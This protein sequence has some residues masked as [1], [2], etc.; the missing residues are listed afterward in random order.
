MLL[1][2]RTFTLKTAGFWTVFGSLFMTTAYAQDGY[3]VT[4]ENSNVADTGGNSG[5]VR[6]ARIAYIQGGASWRTD[7]TSDW[8]TANTNL[9]LRQGAS[10]SVNS[11][12]RTEVQ[13]DDGS[14][15][16]LGS[17]T[18]V[19]FQTLYSDAHGEFTELKFNTGLASITLVSKASVFQLDT[20]LTSIKAQGPANIRI[21]VSKGVEVAVRKGRIECA[22]SQGSTILNGGD[23]V[24]MSD[25][26][27]PL[28]VSP[29]PASDNWDQFNDNRDTSYNQPAPYIPSN[30]AIMSG[31]L[32][33]YGSWSAH[34]KYGHIWRP[35]GMHSGWRPYQDGHWVWVDPFGW[36]W[37]GTE[38]WGW[39]PYHYGSWLHDSVGWG[40]APG[41]RQ[42]Y[43]SPAV[44]SFSVYN[45]NVA[46]V[47][48]SPAEMV[49]PAGISF[50][51]QGGDWSLSFAIGGAAAYYP[52][53]QG[54]VVGRP[55]T[56]GYLNRSYNVYNQNRISGLY[57]GG[58]SGANNQF[59]PTYGRSS[60][61]ITRTTS[62]GFGGTGRYMAGTSVDANNFQ[63]GHSFGAGRSSPSVFGPA[64]VRPVQTS[65]TASRKFGA[66]RPYA[67]V[68]DRSVIRTRLPAEALKHSAPMSRSFAPATRAASVTRIPRR[69]PIGNGVRS[70]GPVRVPNN[71]VGKTNPVRTNG[72]GNQKRT[73]GSNPVQPGRNQKAAPQKRQAVQRTQK[74]VPQNRQAVQRAQKAAPQKRQAVQRTQKA[75]PQKRQ[76]VQRTQKAAPQKRQ[77]VQRTQKAAPQQRQAVQRQQRPAPQQ[78]Q[79]VQRQQRPA[80]QQRQA[81]QRQQRP[82]TQQRQPM[83]RQQRAAPQKRP[84]TRSNGPTTNNKKRGGG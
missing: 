58:F 76:A 66:T 1:N 23:Y 8:S 43:W 40:W 68:M 7:A 19:T 71:T 64:S 75:A 25:G 4:Q 29:L 48:L 54:Y 42:Q 80:T 20:P 22:G 15:L 2:A 37:V 69:T 51:Y 44:V 33:S 56:N 59:Q 65:F 84:P 52:G 55:W 21:G 60:F 39:A 35:R 83:Q 70:T 63:R 53:G 46:W 38:E 34:A 13:F 82:A 6:M 10:I 28:Q 74:A 18:V 73:T 17:G 77:A 31:N 9:P 50:G 27:S 26:A 79:A 72:L 5:P 78:R 47:P 36:T 30:V 3:R 57:A 61:A 16:R 12:S 32:N 62:A 14:R 49:Y 41:P 81:V 45:S 24:N 67:G 11:G